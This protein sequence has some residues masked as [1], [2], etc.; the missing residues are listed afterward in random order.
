MAET[1]VSVDEW[2]LRIQQTRSSVD[3]LKLLEQF[4]K[5]DWTDIERQKIS[6]TYMRVLDGILKGAGENLK[7]AKKAAAGNEGPVWYEK[8]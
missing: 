2:V 6:H 7:S 1:K 3:L 4:R 5:Y 8:M